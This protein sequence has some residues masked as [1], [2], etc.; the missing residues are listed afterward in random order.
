MNDIINYY[1]ELAESY[2]DNRFSN[3][4]GKYIDKQERKILSIILKDENEIIL[5]LAC[6]TGRLSNFANIGI[7]ASDKMIDVAKLKYPLKK[8]LVGEANKIDLEDNSIDTIIC[9]HLF[10]HLDKNMMDEIL[11]ECFR[12]LKNNGRLIFDIPSKKR[13]KLIGYKSNSW[14][15]AYS[16]TIK[17]VK[18]WDNYKVKMVYG[19]LF[20]PIHR[21]PPQL[22]GIFSYFDYVLAQSIFKEYSSYLILE[23]T[24]SDNG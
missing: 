7:D 10:M 18:S 8:F 21:L 5:D 6:G 23:C 1:N 24:K 16:L 15:G 17:D 12:V 13:R 3:S 19:Y 2:D 14:H 4:Y 11:N 9:F 20:F 22:R